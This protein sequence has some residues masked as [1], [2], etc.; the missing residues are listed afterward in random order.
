[1]APP[2]PMG[3]MVSNEAVPVVLDGNETMI[4]ETQLNETMLENSTTQAAVTA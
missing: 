2:F 1:M 3:L 4:N